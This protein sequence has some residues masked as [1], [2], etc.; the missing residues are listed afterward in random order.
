LADI[1]A[2]GQAI[3]PEIP[4]AH[5][6]HDK[7][8]LP[9][10]RSRCDRHTDAAVGRAG[11]GRERDQQQED[12]PHNLGCPAKKEAHFIESAARNL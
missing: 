1:D 6:I 2:G 8:F 5:R 11:A 4:V 10:D 12:S 7:L 9:V 3:V